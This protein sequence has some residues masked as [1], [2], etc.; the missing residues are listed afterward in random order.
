MAHE[1]KIIKTS[2]SHPLR[3]DIVIRNDQAGFI[4]ITFCPG[5][6]GPGRTNTLWRRDLKVDFQQLK[7]HGVT[8]L[9]CTMRED[10]LRSQG[11]ADFEL[12]CRETE[13]KLV[14]FPLDEAESFAVDTV[15][16]LVVDLASRFYSGEGIVV[17]SNH[18]WGRAGVLVA[19]LLLKLNPKLTAD[20]AI[21]QV[22]NR[23]S[24]YCIIQRAHVEFVRKFAEFVQ[25]S[26][27]APSV[28][29]TDEDI[30][31]KAESR[32]SSDTPKNFMIGLDGSDASHVAFRAVMSLFHGDRDT[33]FLVQIQSPGA[34]LKP[35]HFEV[36]YCHE[37]NVCAIIDTIQC[38]F[39]I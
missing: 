3:A 21:Q 10:E 30:L 37:R 17:F 22:R 1:E 23:R 15:D 39:V 26:V 2:Q 34:E 38:D 16:N 36:Q 25:K 33:L 14:S 32:W 4:G 19:C 5:K 27:P 9:V 11:V 31:R 20:E 35:I 28:E 12:R 8:T 18:G 7:E 29:E 13:I 6:Q 24:I